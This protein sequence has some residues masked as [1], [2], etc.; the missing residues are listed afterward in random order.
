M[1]GEIEFAHRNCLS[2]IGGRSRRNRSLSMFRAMTFVPPQLVVDHVAEIDRDG[3]AGVVLQRRPPVLLV[4][5]SRRTLEGD[6]S[7]GRTRLG[8]VVSPKR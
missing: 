1:Q 3:T 4:P 6:V 8:L 2:A 5:G 7:A